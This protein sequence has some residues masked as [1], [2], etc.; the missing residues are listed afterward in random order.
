MI[1][2]KNKK[3]FLGEGIDDEDTG[4]FGYGSDISQELYDCFS[5]QLMKG[6]YIVAAAEGESF[7]NNDSIKP[8]SIIWSAFTLLF[9]I[10][11]ARSGIGGIIVV[12]PFVA[13]AVALC[14]AAWFSKKKLNVAVTNQRMLVDNGKTA[15]GIYLK[16]IGT[17]MIY[18]SGRNKAAIRFDGMEKPYVESIM[19]D[20]Y[21]GGICS[22][23]ME[24]AQ[25]L[26]EIIN[27][28]AEQKR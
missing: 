25:E 12:L 15:S 14:K 24:T 4:L 26:A 17:A 13:V 21:I 23:S 8:V 5:V 19:C 18:P 3:R 16:H 28:S 11:F 6:E 7:E 27:R 9:L 22:L 1:D 20:V 2:E 10:V